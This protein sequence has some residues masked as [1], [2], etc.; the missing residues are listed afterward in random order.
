MNRHRFVTFA[1]I[2][3]LLFCLPAIVGAEQSKDDKQEPIKVSIDD[4]AKAPKKLEGRDI[5]VKGVVATVSKDKN[6]FTIVG[7]K[8]CGGCPAKAKCGAAEIPIHYEG[9]IPSEKKKVAVTGRLVKSEDGKY[10]VKAVRVD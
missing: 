8:A 1:V 4:L 6:L 3:G 9:K 10:V 5:T 7:S 2:V